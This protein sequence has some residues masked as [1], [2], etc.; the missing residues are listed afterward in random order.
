[1]K[2]VSLVLA[3]AAMSVV[4][5]A[6]SAAASQL[7]VYEGEG[8]SGRSAVISACGTSNLPYHGS[9]K[10]YSDGQSGRMYNQRDAQ[11][12]ANFTLAPDRNAEQRTSVGWQSIFIV[13]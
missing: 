7:V 1:M 8:F 3:A 13:C 12:V 11:G 5:A 6:G 2:R 4:A 9:Y 10:W